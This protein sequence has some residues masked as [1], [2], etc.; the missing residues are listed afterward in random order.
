MIKLYRS[1]LHQGQW[2]AQIEGSGWIIFPASPNGWEER[3]PARGLDPM[4][5]RQVP[6]EL[7]ESAG[8]PQPE[9]CTVA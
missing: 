4:H 5:L 1:A 3:Q 7:A 9:G 6:V 2:I 8:I